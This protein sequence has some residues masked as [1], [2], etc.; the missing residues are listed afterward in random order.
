MYDFVQV[1]IRDCRIIQ[2]VVT[3]ATK[4]I[5]IYED[6]LAKLSLI[7][8]GDSRS[9]NNGFGWIAVNV[10][11]WSTYRLGDVGAISWGSSMWSWS[12]ESN[13][14]VHDQMNCSTN[15]EMRSSGYFQA[16]LVYTLTRVTRVTV[17][18]KKI[19]ITKWIF[20]DFTISCIQ[21]R[22]CSSTFWLTEFVYL[23]C[24]LLSNKYFR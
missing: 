5:E 6:V 11:H 4:A 18:L 10:D 20:S 8:K 3:P 17:D 22:N 7:L 1:R 9:A 21:D 15:L 16:F 13:L 19:F 23:L 2:F 12:R 24:K 14:I